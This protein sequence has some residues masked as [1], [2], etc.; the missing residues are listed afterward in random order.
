ML[1]L[2]LV[3]AGG[4]AASRHGRHRLV[5]RKAQRSGGLFRFLPLSGESFSTDVGL[6]EISGQSLIPPQRDWVGTKFAGP[7]PPTPPSWPA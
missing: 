1:L 4:P 6:G 5:Q 7:S 3:T 2:R